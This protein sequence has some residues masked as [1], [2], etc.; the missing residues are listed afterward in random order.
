MRPRSQ[1]EDHDGPEQTPMAETVEL[2]TLLDLISRKLTR[3]LVLPPS[4]T[5]AIALWILF[6]HCHHA[7]L[8]SPVRRCGKT[9][10]LNLISRLVPNAMPTANITSA[11]LYRV[12]QKLSPTLLIDEADTFLDHDLTLQGIMNAGHFRDSAYVMRATNK[13]PD[14]IENLSVWCPKLI[15][16][17]G[18]LPPT[19]E[20]RSIVIR[21]AR[22]AAHETVDRLVPHRD[23]ELAQL[24]DAAASWAANNAVLIADAEPAIPDEL[25]DRA[26][27]NWRQLLAIADMAG[28]DWAD[29]ARS[30]AIALSDIEQD[31]YGELLLLD[32]KEIFGVRSVDRLRSIDIVAENKVRSL[33]RPTNPQLKKQTQFSL[34]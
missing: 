20:D 6:A 10:A 34:D 7:A 5:D 23:E 14:G 19:L 21:L 32:L 9:T 28:K 25:N 29:R 1:V 33:I 26:A 16:M 8:V 3:H 27:D 22:K 12:I 18:K 4:A 24:A 11:A 31:S 30:A 15:A 2:G 17:I 13:T